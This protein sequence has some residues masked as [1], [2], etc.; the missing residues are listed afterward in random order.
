MSCVHV[1]VYA[2]NVL[3]MYMFLQLSTGSVCLI[4]NVE[5]CQC[6]NSSELCHV[7]CQINEDSC[8]STFKLTVSLKLINNLQII[9][10]WTR[11]KIWK[12]KIFVLYSVLLDSFLC[13]NHIMYMFMCMLVIHVGPLYMYT[14]ACITDSYVNMYM[15]MYTAS[16]D[17]AYGY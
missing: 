1:H 17:V 16:G 4:L 7:C 12:K 5:E 11:P 2:V 14:C 10:I 13:L 15:Y 3:Y 9:I 6:R 8:I